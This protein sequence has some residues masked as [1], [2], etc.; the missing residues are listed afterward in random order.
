MNIAEEIRHALEK[1]G[2]PHEGIS[3]NTVVTMSFG[4]ATLF[5]IRSEGTVDLIAAAD[6]ALY[7]AKELGRNR[8]EK[9]FM[10]V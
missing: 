2:L 7:R 6:R 1:R 10:D 9:E 4:V 3:G 5:P 8:V